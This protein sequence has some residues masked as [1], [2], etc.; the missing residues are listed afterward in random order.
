ML[1]LGMA[2]VAGAG[3]DARAHVE[4]AEHSLEV[5]V[6]SLEAPVRLEAEQ[7][8][9]ARRRDRERAECPPERAAPVPLRGGFRGEAEREATKRQADLRQ[10]A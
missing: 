10:T 6:R 5:L 7:A 2:T 9:G 1:Q 4:G 8:E 3:E